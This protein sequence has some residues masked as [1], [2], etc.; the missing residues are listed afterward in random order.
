MLYEVEFIKNKKP[1][2]HIAPEADKR[3]KLKFTFPSLFLFLKRTANPTRNGSNAP[4]R[5]LILKKYID[6]ITIPR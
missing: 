6:V 4:S 5:K 3:K 2:L 1:K